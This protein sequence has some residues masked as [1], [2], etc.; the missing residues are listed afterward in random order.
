MSPTVSERL[1]TTVNRLRHNRNPEVRRSCELAQRCVPSSAAGSYGEL[2][3][4]R[5]G[6]AGTLVLAA[7]AA[8]AAGTE[9]AGQRDIR[10]RE[11]DPGSG[12][13][14]FRERSRARVSAGVLGFC[15]SE[16]G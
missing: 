15:G 16:S 9:R 7:A 13:R 11:V 2:C 12:Q 8:A 3:G 5:S 10:G 4:S 14:E 6:R 1:I